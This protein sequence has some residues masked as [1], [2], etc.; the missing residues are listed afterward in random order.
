MPPRRLKKKSVKS[1]ESSGGNTGNV[2]GTV[3]VQG[4]S[5]KTFMNGKPYIFNE[6]E[7]GVG[8]RR[9]EGLVNADHIPWT[10][11]K[12]MMTME[13]CPATEIKRMEQELWTL[14]LKGDDIEAYN[15]RF[16]ELALMSPELVP[17]EKKKIERYTRR[18]PKRIK[19]NITSSKPTTL[20]DAINMARELVEQAVQGRAIRIGESN[21]RKWEDHQRNNNNNNNNHNNNNRNRNNNYHQQQNRRQETARAYA[22]APAEGRGYAGNLPRCNRCNSHHNGQCPPKCQKCQRTGHQEKDCRVRVPGAGVTPL[23]DVT[24]YGCGEK[25]HYK[26]KCPKGKNQ[27]NDGACARAYVVVENPQQNP[28]VVAGT[29]LLNDHYTCILFDS[30]AEKSFVSSAFTPFIDIAPTAL[31]TS[32]EVELAD[33]KVVSTN[34]VLHCH[35][36]IVRI[37]LPN[38]EI[39]EVQGERPKKDP[40]SLACI[41][42]DE[43]KLDDIRVVRDFPDVIQRE[44]NMRQTAVDQPLLSDYECGDQITP[45]QGKMWWQEAL[46]RNERPK[47]RRNVSLYWW[48][49]M[50]RVIELLPKAAVGYDTIWVIVDRLTKLVSFPYLF[51][52]DYQ[53]REAGKEIGTRL[54]MSTNLTPSGPTALRSERIFRRVRIIASCC[55]MDFG[56]SWDYSSSIDYPPLIWMKLEKVAYWYQKFVQKRLKYDFSTQEKIEKSTRSRRKKGALDRSRLIRKIICFVEEPLVIVERCEEAKRILKGL[57]GYEDGRGSRGDINEDGFC[58][59]SKISQWYYSVLP[60]FG[61]LNDGNLSQGNNFLQNVTCFGCGEKGHYKDKCPKARNQQNDGARARA[62]VVVEN[63][64]QNPNVVTGTF[65]LNDHYACI[66]FDSGAEKSFVSSAFTPFIDIAPTALNTR[67]FDVIIGMDWLA[68]HR[69]LIDC[70]EKIV[71]IPLPNGEI[72]EV[73]GERLEKDLGSLACIKADEKKLDDIRIVRDFPEVFPD[74]LLGLPHVREVEFRIDLIPGAS[75]VVRSPYRLAPSEM[76]ELSN[77]LKELQEKGFIRPSHSPWGAPV[78]FVKKKDDLLKTEMLYAK[79]SKCEFWLKEVQF[80]GHVVNRDGIHVDPSKVESVKNWK[81][82]ESPTEIRSFLGLAGYYRRFIE[83]FSKIAKPLTLLTQKNKAYVWGDKQ[84]EAFQ[85]LKEKL[86]NAPV[87]ALPDGPDDFVV[88]CDASKQGFGCVLMQ[89]G[90]VIAYASRQLK[91]HENNYTT[92][93]L[94]LGAVVFALKIWRHYLYGTKSVIYTDHKSLQYIFDQKELNMRQRRWIELLSDYECEIKYHPGKANVVADALSRKERL[95]PRRVRAMSITIH[96][97]LKTKILEAQSEASKDL[98]A[99]AEWLRGL[100]RHF[101]QRADGEIYFFDRIWIPSIGDVRKLIMDEAHTSRYSVHP[102]ADKMYYDLRDLYWWPGIKRDI[103]EY[104]SRCLTYSKIKA[105]HQKP[106][107]FLQQPEIPEWKWEK[108]AMDF[109]TKLPK[110]SSGYDT[111]WVIVDRLT[112][113]AHFLPIR[114][115]YKTEKLAKIYVNEIVARHGVPVSIISDRDGRFMS[116]LWQAFQKALGT[117]LDKSMAY[118][119]QTDGQSESTIQTLEDML[120]A[121]VMDFGGSWD[122]HLPLIE[123]SYNNS[124]HTSIKCAPFEALY[125]RKCR[126]PVIW[127]EVGESQ[128]IGPEIMQETT[129]KIV[130]IMERLKTARSRQKSYADKRRKPLEFQVGDRVLLKLPQE[131]SCVHDTFHVSNLKKCLAEPDVQVPLDEIEIDENLRFVEQPIKIVDRDV[132]KLKRK[133]ILLVKVCWNSRQ[134]AEY[135]WEHEDQFRMKYPHL[136]SEPVLSSSAAT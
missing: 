101:E 53:K 12:T 89:Q 99:P 58:V 15:N 57:L 96:S 70:Y 111:I 62:Y 120:R 77:Q 13:Y 125:G 27:Q 48:P 69:A 103:A 92:H 66:L 44:L 114:E 20:H 95:K 8:L 40:G 76:L 71:C 123:F 46:S 115:D 127:T 28:N 23:Q 102:G 50:K 121:C 10:E 36:K 108:L 43:K 106:S 63:P 104:I 49:G 119:P 41:K 84:E 117:R 136:F 3:N 25:G 110:S 86:C 94:E 72:L 33:G 90:K 129:E 19:G 113:S 24:C 97:G 122:T 16:H 107:G 11:F 9:W 37:P 65:L 88:Y 30:G 128:L 116:H 22:A 45:R 130:Q 91:I 18:F 79:F 7:G 109:I 131:L 47:P 100:E 98:K 112:K 67:S 2:G 39:L 81:T 56:G 60:D 132:K 59:L 51:S 5:H 14:T 52:E 54:V 32:Y 35:E 118:H 26:D 68:Y 64:Q 87:L 55:D 61:V 80:L 133:R 93:D 135:T 134:G 4:C 74:D 6:T 124:Y 21:K 105:E 78:L 31:N 42:A 73:Q 82:P 29:F 38:G 17:T 126:S 85:I 75:P 83:N 34:N 1:A